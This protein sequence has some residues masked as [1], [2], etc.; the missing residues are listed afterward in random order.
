M[1]YYNLLKISNIIRNPRFKFLGLYAL[2]QL[3]RR[4]LSVYFD[5][6]NACNLRCKMCYFTD[7]D[8]VKN[9]KG[10]FFGGGVAIACKGSFG[11][12]I[13]TANRMWCRTD[14]FRRV[15]LCN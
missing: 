14:A 5:P 6:I 2:H 9:T 12:G 13:E 11:Q 3:R 15:E 1:N 7:I 10:F 4:Y 8:Y